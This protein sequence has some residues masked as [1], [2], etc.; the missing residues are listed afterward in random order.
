MGFAVRGHRHVY[1]TPFSGD[2]FRHITDA[3]LSRSQGSLMC[4]DV[5]H[6]KYVLISGL[7]CVH[8]LSCAGMAAPELCTCKCVGYKNLFLF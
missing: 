8:S 5:R 6:L 7:S 4:T 3:S 1:R 2:S